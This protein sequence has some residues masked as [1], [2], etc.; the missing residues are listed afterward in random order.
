MSSIGTTGWKLV[1]AA[2]RN[3]PHAVQTDEGYLVV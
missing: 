2:L 3:N 1:V